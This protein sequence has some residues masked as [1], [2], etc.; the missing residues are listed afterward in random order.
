VGWI[1]DGDLGG[2]PMSFMSGAKAE[3]TA[4]R[5]AAALA[6]DGG[7]ARVVV[8]DRSGRVVGST[9]TDQIGR[10]MRADL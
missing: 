10:R 7:S 2:Y 6:H 3:L 4:M 5:L 8:R 9:V 1:V